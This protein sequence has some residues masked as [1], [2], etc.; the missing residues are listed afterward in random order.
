MTTNPAAA[1]FEEFVHG[2]AVLAFGLLT[3]H[4]QARWHGKPIPLRRTS[5]ACCASWPR[6]P[7]RVLTRQELVDALGEGGGPGVP[8]HGR[9]VDQALSFGLR[10]AGGTSALRT[11][12]G[13][14]CAL[15]LP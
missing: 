8:A 13:K 12:H 5:S 9:R 7:N 1:R 4:E 14:G 15:D 10:N 3:A 6:T 2:D 11:V